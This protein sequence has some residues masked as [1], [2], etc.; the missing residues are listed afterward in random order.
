MTKDIVV[1]VCEFSSRLQLIIAEDEKE[2]WAYPS[3]NSSEPLC[4]WSVASDRV[5]D[6]HQHQEQ[7]HQQS[8][9]TCNWQ[10]NSCQVFVHKCLL[11]FLALES[12]QICLIRKWISSY[13]QKRVTSKAIRTAIGIWPF[14]IYICTVDDEW[15]IMGVW[16]HQEQSDQQCN[17]TKK[18]FLPIVSGP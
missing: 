16:K 2:H 4:L 17:S 6:V 8:H 18:L 7:S 11:V 12:C 10:I 13:Q 3:L 15:W 9:S 5:E 1:F 14:H